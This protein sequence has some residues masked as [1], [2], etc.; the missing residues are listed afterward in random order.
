MTALLTTALTACAA[1]PR[2]GLAPATPDHRSDVSAALLEQIKAE[3]GDAACDNDQQCVSVAIG[4]KA[5]GGPETYFAWSSK[6]G[7]RARL[8]VLVTR[9]REARLLEIE[10]SGMVSNCSMVPNPGVVCRPRATDGKRVCQPGQGGQS[11]LD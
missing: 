3:I 9:H 11:R 8:V 2:S 1:T 7:D 4:A 6:A 5:C 10:R